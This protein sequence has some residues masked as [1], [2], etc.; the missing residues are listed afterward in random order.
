MLKHIPAVLS[1]DEVSQ[2][3]Q[4]MA[5]GQFESGAAT[6]SGRAREVKNNLQFERR[7]EVKKR[8]D[9]I[10]IS[11]LMRNAEF[12]AF[13]FARLIVPPTFNRYDVGM[14]YGSHVDAPFLNNGQVRADLS[15]TV[16]LSDP[17]TYEGGELVIS[18]GNA[19]IRAKHASG[20]CVVYPTTSLH[21]VSPVTRGAPGGGVV[22]GELR[23]GRARQGHPARPQQGE[24]LHGADRA[25]GARNRP[26]PQLRVQPD[27]PVVAHLGATRPPT[28]ARTK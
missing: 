9:Q 11:A 18:S 23:A 15:L 25:P 4:I 7:P 22:G 26:V 12:I 21:H 17:G 1:Q 20:D 13:S 3:F 14:F 28:R 2:I 24:G 16:F 27:A 6:A 5:E 8:L 19:E 10:V